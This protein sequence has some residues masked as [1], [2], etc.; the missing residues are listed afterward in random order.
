MKKASNISRINDILNRIDIIF[1]N[2]NDKNKSDGKIMDKF[3][4]IKEI[5]IILKTMM[6]LIV[7]DVLQDIENYRLNIGKDIKTKILNLNKCFEYT[8]YNK[9]NIYGFFVSKFTT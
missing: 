1:A 7:N 8:N 5:I 3:D 2:K 4:K 6:V 9:I